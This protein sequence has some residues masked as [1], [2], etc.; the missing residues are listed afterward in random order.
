MHFQGIPTSA[1]VNAIAAVLPP[2]DLRCMRFE[3]GGGGGRGW[4]GANV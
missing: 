3:E 2:D 1:P 4:W